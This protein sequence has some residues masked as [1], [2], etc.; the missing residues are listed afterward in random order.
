MASDKAEV[1]FI[2]TIEEV[3]VIDGGNAVTYHITLDNGFDPWVAVRPEDVPK[4]LPLLLLPIQSASKDRQSSGQQDLV[5]L[6]NA[7]KAK[8]FQFAQL[9]G[10]KHL[11]VV[12][13]SEEGLQIPFVLSREQAEEI[14]STF[15]HVIE[16]WDASAKASRSLKP[17]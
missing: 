15:Q 10:G 8:Q 6:E 16:N 12:L 5:S 2:E 4:F 13:Q 17:N 14:S 3:G 9:P 7:L 11:A 1:H